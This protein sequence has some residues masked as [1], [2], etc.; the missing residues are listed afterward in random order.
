MLWW[1]KGR[2]HK[3]ED[4]RVSSKNDIILCTNNATGDDIIYLLRE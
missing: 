1:K 3:V 4:R 2:G